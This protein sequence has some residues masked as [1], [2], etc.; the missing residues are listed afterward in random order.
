MA[1]GCYA[2]VLELEARVNL[3]SHN[4]S[5]RL[6]VLAASPLISNII[7]IEVGESRRLPAEFLRQQADNLREEDVLELIFFSPVYWS[8]CALLE[9]LCGRENIVFGVSTA[10]I[11]FSVAVFPSLGSSFDVS[12]R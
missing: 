3:D 4:A 2:A 9:S 12:Q 5:N 11:F 10:D 6:R 7:W 8:A 1:N